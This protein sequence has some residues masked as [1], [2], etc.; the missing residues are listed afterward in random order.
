MKSFDDEIPDTRRRDPFEPTSNLGR[1]S[2]ELDFGVGSGSSPDFESFDD[3]TDRTKW[4]VTACSCTVPELSVET[5]EVGQWRFQILECA[6][7]NTIIGHIVDKQE[8]DQE[9]SVE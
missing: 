3:S 4:D 9:A 6:G 2:L 5:G 8:D 7:C 1:D